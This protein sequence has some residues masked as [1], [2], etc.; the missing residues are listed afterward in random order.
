M[1]LIG[2]ASQCGEGSEHTITVLCSSSKPIMAPF[3][4]ALPKDPVL[5]GLEVNSE[6]PKKG[7]EKEL[8]PWVLLRDPIRDLLGS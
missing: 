2:E 1:T 8:R 5:T 4:L 7:E 3:L 6:L